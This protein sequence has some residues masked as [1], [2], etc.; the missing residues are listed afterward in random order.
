[1][2]TYG[3]Q[4]IMRRLHAR[5][6]RISSS[7]PHQ[8]RTWARLPAMACT[9]ILLPGERAELEV[10]WESSSTAAAVAHRRDLPLALLPAVDGVAMN[11]VRTATLVEI[12]HHSPNADGHGCTIAVRGVF[13]ANVGLRRREPLQVA[14]VEAQ[15]WRGDDPWWV[16][17]VEELSARLRRRA[18]GA[19]RIIGGR[20]RSYDA[21]GF[22]QLVIELASWL[23]PRGGDRYL[24][25][26]GDLR[27]RL[28][29]LDQAL[30]RRIEA[31]EAENSERAAMREP[32]KAD[33]DASTATAALPEHV[34]TAIN[35]QRARNSVTGGEA[36]RFLEAMNWV[37]PEPAAIDLRAARA[38]LD[39]RCYGMDTVK[40]RVLD[41]LASW[42]WSRRQGEGQA[43]GKVL[44]LLGP[45]GVGKTAIAAVIADVMSR[46][47]RRIAMGGT[48][49]VYLVG[50][51]QAYSHSQPGA[52]A[53]N[54]K[55][56]KRHP[57]DV[58]F[59]LDEIDKVSAGHRSAVPVLLALLDPQQNADFRD[60]F[61]D[62]V[63][64]DLSQTVFVCTANN[65]ED[66]PAP[67]RDRLQPL[68]LPG[69]TRDEQIVIARKHLLPR[70][71]KRLAVG[72][73]VGLAKDVVEALIDKS[74]V[75]P[76][77]R[78]LQGQLETVMTRGLR[79]HMERAANVWVTPEMALAWTG[80]TAGTQRS[81]STTRVIGFK[82]PSAAG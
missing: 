78:Q 29:M 21:M 44:C 9:T 12:E 56:S 61:L 58:V 19:L 16:A 7:Q 64:I 69:Y 62:T 66:I 11:M 79:Q 24:L 76:G 4:G 1:M 26:A 71:R 37:A 35:A 6:H 34:R 81:S 13:T 57:G 45:P 65:L 32:E 2:T 54:I 27:T 46:T 50:S 41:L 70:L 49:D 23:I 82:V 55:D 33:D 73:E 74:P 60:Q 40:E 28:Q 51:D 77:M 3:E 75:S 15:T 68:V 36:A 43:A 80:T 67:L 52:I 72:E 30:T 63:P 38:Q 48:D 5:V 25:L 39:Q 47:M 22:D 17:D 14:A 20:E 31:E 42:E 10:E 8:L 18:P 59:L 53:R